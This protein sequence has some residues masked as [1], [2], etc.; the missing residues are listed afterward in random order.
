M[1]KVIRILFGVFI[2]GIVALMGY[3][4]FANP[5]EPVQA[6][7]SATSAPTPAKTSDA[8]PKFKVAWS[9]YAGWMPWDY[10]DKKGIV[11][12]WADKYNIEIEVVAVN[13]YI[14]SINQYTSGEF[15]G[16]TM[17]NMDALTIPAAGGVDSTAIIIGD[18]SNGN[19][20]ILLKGGSKVS[21]L[22]GK[23][24]NLVEFSVSHYL[25]SRALQKNG[26]GLKDVQTVN[27]SDSNLV[28]A[29]GSKDVSAI[30][31][32]NPILDVASKQANSSLIFSSKE[33]PGEILDLMVVNTE[34]LKAHPELGKALTGAWYETVAAMQGDSDT[35]KSA[36]A[37][38]AEAAGTDVAS[39]NQQLAATYFFTDASKAMAFIKE[40]KLQ[41]GMKQ[42]AEFSFDNGLLGDKAKSAE[43]IGI[44]TPEGQWGDKANLKLHISSEFT[45]MAADGKL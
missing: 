44:E 23:K 6:K 41:S 36:R 26:M 38:M 28:A 18:Y 45:Q 35:A 27:S 25:L 11:K 10:A 20:G 8:K 22:K 3:K 7:S 14:Q 21:D 15:A 40:G 19:D 24:I 30:V 2:F 42:V 33:I 29:F 9:I 13:D 34:V 1:N 12:K 43:H 5:S 16:V 17:T 39:F 31:T 4:L 32:W 37:F